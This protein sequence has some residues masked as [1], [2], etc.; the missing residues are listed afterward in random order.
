MTEVALVL[1]F[2]LNPQTGTIMTTTNQDLI[3]SNRVRIAVET[4][5]GERVMRP[6]YGTKIPNALFNTVDGF[7]DVLQKEIGR[8][9]VDQ[10]PLLKLVSISTSH[11]TAYN[12]LSVN[13]TYQLPNNTE[14]TT[15]A[16]VMVISNVNPPYQELTS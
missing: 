3:W 11:D 6:T 12:K 15:K 4:A 10:L 2:S 14:I 9:F 1:P 13:V 5:L 7:D 8:V 16:G